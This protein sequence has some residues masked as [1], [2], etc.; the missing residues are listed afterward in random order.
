MPH[1]EAPTPIEII[2]LHPTFAA[3]VHGVD[4]SKDIPP[5]VFAEIKEA[6]TKVRSHKTRRRSSKPILRLG[7]I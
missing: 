7:L 3:E 4:F 1:K 6:I 5:E 2:P